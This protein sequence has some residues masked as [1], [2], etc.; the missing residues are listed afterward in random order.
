MT[1][2][3]IATLRA[4]LL[5]QEL[6]I[7]A[8]RVEITL[9]PNSPVYVKDVLI[10]RLLQENWDTRP[11]YFGMTAGAENYLSLSEYLTQE[12]LIFRLHPMEPPDTSRLAPGL[13]GVPMDVARTD[14]LAWSIFR[15]AGLF[16][17]DSLDMDPTSRNI[18]INL[19]YPFY[20]L[21]NAYELMGDLQNA[22]RNLRRGYQLNPLPEML[23]LI[24]RIEESVAIRRLPPEMFSDTL[25]GVP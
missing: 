2:E 4:Q 3:Q 17:A 1:D 16:E 12:G 15:Y 25:I 19:S 20:A 13:L 14:S 8:G 11:I 6:R 22:L 24:R 18:G 7:R 23:R 10:F 21:G 9:P 5:R